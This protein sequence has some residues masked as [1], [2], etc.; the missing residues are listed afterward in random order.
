M[1]QG[2]NE[3]RIDDE[4]EGSLLCE[5]LAPQMIMQKMMP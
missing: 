3:D 1:I 2:K 5:S 4:N